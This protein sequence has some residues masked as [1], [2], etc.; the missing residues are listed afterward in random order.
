MGHI[1]F[2]YQN[3]QVTDTPGLLRRHDDDRNNLE[4][5]TLAVLSHLPT[6]V[7]YVHDLSGE[8]GT[9][10]SD[11]FV[12]YKEIKE[13]FSNHLWLDVVSKCDLLQESPVVYV[14]DDSD[15]HDLELAR[16]LRVGPD[17]AI[18]V[19]VNSEAGLN[20]L[21]ARVHGLLLSQSAR[22]K[23][24]EINLETVQLIR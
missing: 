24:Q 18:H 6:A 11:Q 23:S 4:K 20:E 14:T 17:G 10:P 3:F 13:R 7:L 19:S 16:Y 2:N 22:I 5:L 9:S 12:I 8:C 21:K 1:A 15:A